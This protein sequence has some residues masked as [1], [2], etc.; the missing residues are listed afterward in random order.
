M[1][2]EI[3]ALLYVVY[4]AVHLGQNVPE[5]ETALLLFVSQTHTLLVVLVNVVVLK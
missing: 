3:P 4:T 5:L 2:S 1:L